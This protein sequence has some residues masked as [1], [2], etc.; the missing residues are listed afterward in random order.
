MAKQRCTVQ[1]P[2]IH[3]HTHTHTHK[4]KH[5]FKTPIHTYTDGAYISNAYTMMDC[6]QMHNLEDGYATNYDLELPEGDPTGD[7]VMHCLDR[8]I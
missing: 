5:P 1:H 8:N 7:P 2:H 4:S 6:M 3:T